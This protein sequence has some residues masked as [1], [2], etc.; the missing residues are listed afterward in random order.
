[1]SSSTETGYLA[2]LVERVL[3]NVPPLRRRQPAL[4][5]PTPSRAGAAWHEALAGTA[6][7]APAPR[8]PARAAVPA[9][10]AASAPHEPVTQ[11]IEAPPRRRD[12]SADAT[13]P[14]R[15]DTPITPEVIV[16]HRSTT[17]IHE[18]PRVVAT[19]RPM[20]AATP[21]IGQA[22]KPEHAA[23]SA[24]T[25]A[26]VAVPRTPPATAALHAV[27]TLPPRLAAATP[28]QRAATNRDE[29]QAPRRAGASLQPPPRLPPTAPRR[30]Q[31]PA[32]PGPS[33]AASRAAAQAALRQPTP[34]QRERPP[35][36]VTIGRVEVR[37][38]AAPT[39]N[40]RSQPR[41]APRLSLE[42]YLQE[43]HGGA[44]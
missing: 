5:E 42:Q 41:A 13:P 11:T 8:L 20:V 29:G 32:P 43:R 9:R 6:T 27:A 22:P 35:V 18:A 44:R 38:V 2:Q 14:A 10:A 15:T 4:F 1:M 36:E 7:E 16:R 21:P 34:L 3:P 19:V 17:L 40:A 30:P 33:G 25:P 39:G 37:A 26:A 23:A 28:A 24:R 31:T 12:A